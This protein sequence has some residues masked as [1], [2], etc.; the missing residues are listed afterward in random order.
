[1]IARQLILTTVASAAVLAAS[2][3]H[4]ADTIR[5]AYIDPLSGPFAAVG[6]NGLNQYKFHVEQFNQDANVLGKKFEIVGFDS[7]MSPKE[8]LILLKSVIGEG[9][10]FVVQGN[11]SGVASALS[12]AIAKHN[13]RNPDQRVLLLNYSAVDPALTNEKCN[14]W[15]FRFDAHADMKM[16]ALTDVI[17]KDANMKRIY[18]LGQDYSFGKAVAAAAEKYLGE[19]RPDIKIVGNELHPIGK[20][21]DFSPYV[22]KIKAAGAQALI[23]AN[24]G[25]DML[26]LAKAVSDAGLDIAMFT[27]YGAGTGI[28][29]AIGASGV[30]KVKL[31]SQ[32]VENPPHTE[33]WGQLKAAYKK[34]NPDGDIDQPRIATVVRMLGAAINKAGST[35]PFKVATALEGMSYTTQWGDQMT[36]RATDHQLQMPVRIFN[37]TDKN[38]V[39][40]RDNSGY[41]LVEDSTVSAEQASTPTTCKMERPAS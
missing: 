21:K 33:K 26:N 34:A 18:V 29:K 7:K 10:Q 15:H 14:F 31:V 5:I 27:Y 20:V 30:G 36:M 24:W 23:T 19:K 41:G 37:H 1:M 16:N 9:I 4:A 3:S 40:D 22:A 39:F 13:S 38:V 11:S 2:T 25:A 6:N 28:T 32:G 17:A 35:E 12:D 8:S